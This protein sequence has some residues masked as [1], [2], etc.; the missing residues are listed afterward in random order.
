MSEVRRWYIGVYGGE[1]QA[2]GCTPHT[3]EI[4]RDSERE[5]F[6]LDADFERVDAE[7]DALQALLTAADE[8]LDAAVN[9]LETWRTWLGPTRESCDETGKEIWDRIDAVTVLKPAEGSTCNQIREESGL[10]IN[11][12]CQ[13]CGHGACIDR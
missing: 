7:R 2:R 1:A 10:T 6:V 12:P 9:L 5:I 13:A 3:R 11:A 4:I 8:R